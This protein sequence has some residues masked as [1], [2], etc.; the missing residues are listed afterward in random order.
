M[1]TFVILGIVLLVA[2][3]VGAKMMMDQSATDKVKKQAQDEVSSVPDKI[4]CLG[5][6]DIE[7]GVAGLYPKQFGEIVE[8]LPENTKVKKGVVLLQVDDG[9]WKKKIEEAELG[10]KVS[11]LQLK[12]AKQLPKLYKL[13]ADQQ[14]A[15]INA[16]DN[17][18]KKTEFDREI[19]LVG[20]DGA[21]KKNS[22]AYYKFA[23]DQLAEKKKVETS[24]LET[25]GL[26]NAQ[27]KIEQAEADLGL[28]KLKRDQAKEMLKHFQIAAPSDGTVLRVYVHK[29]ETLGPN[30]RYHAIEFLPDAEVIVRAEVLQEWGR[31]VKEGAEVTI[32]DDT[33]NGPKW[34]GK[35]KSMSKWYAA[36]RSTVIE[37]FRY[38]DVRTLECIITVEEG[39]DLKRIGQRVRAMVTKQ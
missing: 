35:V 29:G 21:L 26:Q 25:I 20:I 27:L 15:A 18:I 30:P 37:P 13:Q 36:Q 39:G 33:Y 14:R 19:K 11:E 6:F 28:S 31:F 9:L 1:K 12:E 38:N 2:C 23:L 24:K 4:F 5:H 8:L 22:E 34:K 10:V 17:E 7:R 16:V 32:E 3:F